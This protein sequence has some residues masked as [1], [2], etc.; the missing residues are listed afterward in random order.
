MLEQV[1]SLAAGRCQHAEAFMYRTSSTPV[2]FRDSKLKNIET[3]ESEALALRVVSQGK[4]G[5]STS[6]KA[7]DLQ[8]LVDSALAVAADGQQVTFALPGPCEVKTLD[9]F[10]PGVRDLP[11]ES[12]LEIGQDFVESTNHVDPEILAMATVEK[13]T[14]SVQLANSEGASHSYDKTSYGIFFGG[15]LV[16]EQSFLHVYDGE[17]RTDLNIDWQAIKEQVLGDLALARKNVLLESGRYPVV[18]TPTALQYL[19]MRYMACLNGRAVEKGISPWTDKMGQK[20]LADRVTLRDSPHMQGATGSVPVDDEGTP[21]RDK[22]L[23]ENGVVRSFVLDLVS[24]DRLGL[25][26]TGNGFRGKPLL[27]S[28]PQPSTSNL[29]M[30]SGAGAVGD[31]VASIKRGLLVDHLMGAWAG[32]PYSGEVNGNISLGYLIESGQVV[33]RVKNAMLSVNAFEALSAQLDSI[34]AERKWAW[35]NTYLPYVLLDGVNVATGT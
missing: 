31:M 33:G 17:S 30:D 14:H 16:E 3:V 10:S 12:M 25:S 28:P 4:L 35:G 2:E 15:E 13:A 26:P 32:N 22:P 11:V 19:F 1:L 20:V 29:T 8:A 23:I 24:A 21:T 5:F 18:L 34:S 7:S 9:L 27:N 6:T